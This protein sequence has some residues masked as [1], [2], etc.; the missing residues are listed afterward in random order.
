MPPSAHMHAAGMSAA[1]HEETVVERTC[2]PL[3]KVPLV[4]LGFWVI[5]FMS[6]TVGETGAG[7]LAV[8]MPVSEKASRVPPWPYC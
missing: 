8:S 1:S 5:K 7:Y 6:T 2:G 3:N 4:T